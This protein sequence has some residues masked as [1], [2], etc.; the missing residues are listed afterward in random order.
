MNDADTYGDESYLYEFEFGE[1]ITLYPD[2]SIPGSTDADSSLYYADETSDLNFVQDEQ[3][4]DLDSMI[5]WI[6]HLR[7][8]QSVLN[9]RK[10]AAC[11]ALTALL[12]RGL[13]S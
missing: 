7:L 5:V 4:S 9:F 13:V 3:L 6:E 1:E 11:H 2:E 10:N 12:E 8:Q